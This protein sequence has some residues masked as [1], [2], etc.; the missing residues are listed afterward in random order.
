MKEF[1]KYFIFLSTLFSKREPF[2][3]YWKL[4]FNEAEAIG[5]NSILIVVIFSVFM[6]AVTVIQTSY[7][8]VNPLVSRDVIGMVARDTTILEF[9][10]TVLAIV[11]AG[12]VGS[13]IAGE[14]G[15]MRISEQIDALKVM[16]IN[17]AS[18]LVLP[19]I[20]A[21]I[22]TYPMLVIIACFL[23][24]LG[25]YMAGVYT[26][27]LTDNEYIVG[28]R[29]EFS[30][31]N[32]IFALV[33]SVVFAFLISSISSFKGYFTKGGA[34]EVGKASTSAVTASCIAILFADYL[35]A[36]LLL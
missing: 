22:I 12:K 27:I 18:Y 7:N 16:G 5:I 2:R 6:G 15:T 29:T 24:L 11:F 35:L 26:G 8:L 23:S 13:H 21:S 33:K 17:A 14:L 31:F 3:V 30:G 1:G 28:I 32:I 4:V 19:K 25:G 34:L 36:Q 20:V 9:A 10:P